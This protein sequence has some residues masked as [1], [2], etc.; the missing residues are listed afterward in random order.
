[1]HGVGTKWIL[2][3]LPYFSHREVHLVS[4]QCDPDPEFPTV[5][6]PNP[7]EKGA[8]NRAME[9]A[10]R[11]GSTFIIAN[12]PD[13]DRLAI[14]E[15]VGNS[16]KAFTGNEIGIILGHWMMTHWRGKN[17]GGVSEVNGQEAAPSAVLASVVSSRMLKA[18]A[19]AEG[20]QYFDTLTGKK[21]SIV[22]IV[23]WHD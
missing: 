12:D 23:L 1:M 21:K 2:R 15:K 8:L 18:M 3:A 22:L 7:E 11:V 17:V 4:S 16:W 14:A 6:F 10:D 20:V 19:K 5:S 13:A 9:E